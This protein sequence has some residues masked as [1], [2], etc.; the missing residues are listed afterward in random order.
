MILLL[1]LLDSDKTFMF[2][3]TV[4]ELEGLEVLTGCAR[5]L[6]AAGWGG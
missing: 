5:A 6:S 4:M 3:F 1:K 2:F